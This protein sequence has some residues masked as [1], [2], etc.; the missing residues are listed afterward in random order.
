MPIQ[1]ME[2]RSSKI[3]TRKWKIE[4]R[5]E[6]RT[7]ARLTAAQAGAQPAVPLHGNDYAEWRDDLR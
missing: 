6:K 5:E 2:T 4:N 7:G 3:E 1:E